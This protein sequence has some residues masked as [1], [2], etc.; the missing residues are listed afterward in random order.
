MTP[1]RIKQL[2]ELLAKSTPLPWDANSLYSLLR[3]GAKNEGP[4]CE[5]DE[6]KFLPAGKDADLIVEMRASLEE[7]LAIAAKPGREGW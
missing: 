7:L 3:F 2:R 1:E 4:W 5:G 6:D